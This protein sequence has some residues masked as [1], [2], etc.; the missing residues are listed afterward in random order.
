MSL[1]LSFIIL[2]I[3]CGRQWAC[4]L[5]VT[6]TWLMSIT[7]LQLLAWT[8]RSNYQCQPMLPWSVMNILS[9]VLNI[10]PHKYQCMRQHC[11]D[12]VSPCS[13]DTTTLHWV[14]RAEAGWG[15]GCDMKT[16]RCH[17]TATLLHPY[18]LC[19]TPCGHP[20]PHLLPLLPPRPHLWPPTES[21]LSPGGHMLRML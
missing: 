1:K 15:S 7:N 11:C 10:A 20:L 13:V 18:T 6:L 4:T 16:G 21:P 3:M 19:K 14:S 12:R 2:F 17:N 9:T 5:G 8:F